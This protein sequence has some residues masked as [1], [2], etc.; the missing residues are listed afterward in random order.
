M[1]KTVFTIN[2]G[3][4]SIKCKQ[5][6]VETGEVLAKIHGERLGTEK[7]EISFKSAQNEIRIKKQCNHEGAIALALKLL[8]DPDFGVIKKLDEIDA[9]GHRVVHGGELY[10]KPMLITQKVIDG[11]RKCNSL[12]P[13]HNPACLNGIFACRKLMP[14]KKQVAIFDTAFHQTMSEERFLYPIPRKYYEKYGVRKYGFH[15]ISHNYLA[16]T[17][18]EI[19]GDV[20]MKTVN[21]HLGQGA[22]L[23]A[24]KDGKSIDTTM[25]LSPLAGI[26]MGTRSGDID[27]AIVSYLAAAENIDHNDVIDILNKESGM[28]ALSGVSADFRDILAEADNGNKRAKMALERY[29]ENVAQYAAKF[30]VTLDGA[31]QLVFSGGIGENSPI[32]RAEI[33]KKLHIFGVELDEALN[34]QAIGKKMKISSSH[35]G[36]EVFVIPTNEEL[37]I[38]RQ[39]VQ[40]VE[41]AELEDAKSKTEA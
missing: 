26:L 16:E 13:L 3:S 5:I 41:T 9:I 36:L 11:I 21:F 38:A 8:Q 39:T 29:Y 32:V 31:R 23:C 25:G 17:L 19:I 2:A 14:E 28:L 30:M 20:E 35:S 40:T 1:C 22:S 18:R 10:C 24:V 6:N 4:S 33:C 7:S 27:T 15:G 37:L 34:N 12:A